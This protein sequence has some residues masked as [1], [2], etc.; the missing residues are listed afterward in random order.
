MIYR[1][2]LPALLLAPHLLWAAQPESTMSGR[3]IRIAMAD[4]S[5]ARVGLNQPAK[6]P[7][8]RLSD[9]TEFILDFPTADTFTV[10]TDYCPN[11]RANVTVTY[12]AEHG[13]V[14]LPSEDFSVDILL[15]FTGKDSGC[16]EIVWHEAGNTRY[17]RGA[18]FTVQ[19]EADDI[20]HLELPME[21]IARTGNATATVIRRAQ[22]SP[23]GHY[24]S[25][26]SEKV[27]TLQFNTPDSGTATYSDTSKAGPPMMHHGTFTLK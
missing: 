16:A 12:D 10:V 2:L 19:N 7:W 20:A 3:C 4:A 13:K 6:G 23:G 21:Q 5:V 14:K 26:W 27:F 9:L 15:S 18:T 1:T 24:A 8:Y 22:W 25:G 11:L 17:F